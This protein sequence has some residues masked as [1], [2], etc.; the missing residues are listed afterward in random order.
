MN[1]SP[2]VKNELSARVKGTALKV[3]TD[4]QPRQSFTKQCFQRREL[5]KAVHCQRMR[6]GDELDVRPSVKD[7]VAGKVVR[8]VMGLFLIVFTGISN[9]QASMV[10][11]APPRT[12]KE[13]FGRF[14]KFTELF[15]TERPGGR[16][17]SGVCITLS[18]DEKIFLFAAIVGAV[19]GYALAQQTRYIRGSV[20]R[21]RIF[22]VLRQQIIDAAPV[23]EGLFFNV[24][25]DLNSLRLISGAARQF[26]LHGQ[27]AMSGILDRR[28][29]Q[30]LL[31]CMGK[32]LPERFPDYFLYRKLYASERYQ[33]L[34]KDWL[35]QDL[36]KQEA[37]KKRN[38]CGRRLTDR[39]KEKFA[40]WLRRLYKRWSEFQCYRAG[41]G[42]GITA[43]ESYKWLWDITN[44]INSARWQY[45]ANIGSLKGLIKCFD[46]ALMRYKNDR[47]LKPCLRQCKR[48]FFAGACDGWKK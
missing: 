8:A 22:N 18:T 6:N 17:N 13:E 38:R 46:G 19:T 31:A 28:Q 48:D 43:H 41:S 34:Y 4:R 27:E 11:A 9:F 39:E 5:S 37:R 47:E 14:Y 10:H 40:K 42:C 29:V 3:Q 23:Y 2:Q 26:S 7:L 16:V 20:E 44:S 25:D 45:T 30:A 36:K 1:S 33:A 12:V 24:P 32:Q 35:L 15:L 21:V